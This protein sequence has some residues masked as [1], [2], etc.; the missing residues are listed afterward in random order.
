MHLVGS[1]CLQRLKQGVSQER[2]HRAGVAPIL[3]GIASPLLHMRI[4]GGA[5]ETWRSLGARQRV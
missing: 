1:P 4:L 5:H 3:P 2:C